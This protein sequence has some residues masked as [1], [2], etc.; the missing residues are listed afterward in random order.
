MLSPTHPSFV[1]ILNVILISLIFLIIL[2]S[3]LSL[4]S[5]ISASFFSSFVPVLEETATPLPKAK[6]HVTPPRKF[7]P[8]WVFFF[9]KSCFFLQN[10]AKEEAVKEEEVTLFLANLNLLR[11]FPPHSVRSS[12]CTKASQSEMKN[13]K[14]KAQ[15]KKPYPNHFH[16]STPQQF[17]GTAPETSH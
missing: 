1:I 9:F 15:D 6:G 8:T 2:R 13:K 11:I 7:A 17:H 16:S 14:K 10:T 5:T 4:H 12:Q 3:N